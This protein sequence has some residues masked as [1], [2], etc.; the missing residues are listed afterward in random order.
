MEIDYSGLPDHIRAG[1][2]IYIEDH[3]LPGDFITACLENNLNRAFAYADGINRERLRDVV[4]FLHNEAP[5]NCWG[6]Q[7]K[8]KAWVKARKS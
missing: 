3:R 4:L 5:G 1:F 7:E 6:S 2:K 8:V